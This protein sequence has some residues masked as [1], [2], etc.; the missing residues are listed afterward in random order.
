M[1]DIERIEEVLETGALGMNLYRPIEASETR[2]RFKIYHADEAVPLSNILPMMENMGFKVLGEVPFLIQVRDRSRGGAASTR[3][4]W[5]HDFEVELAG[6]G[7]IAL[8]DIRDDFQ[9]AFARVWCGA[10]ENDGFNRLVILAGL[11]WREVVV[12]RAYAKYLRQVSFTFAQTTL[13]ATLAAYPGLTRALVDLFSAWFDPAHAPKTAAKL[14]ETLLKSIALALDEV[15]SADDDRILRRFLDLVQN[16][17]RTNYFRTGEDGNPRPYLS[18]KLDSRKLDDLPLPRP[19]REIWVYSPA[20]EGIHLRG[21][22]VARGGLRWSD[23]RE[24]FRTEILGLMKAQMVKNAVIVP[25]GSKGGFVVKRPPPAEAG[26]EAWLTE[27]IACYKT[28]IRGLLDLTDNIAGPDIVPPPDVVRRDED[29][30]YLVVAADKGTASFSDIANGISL[31]YGFWLGDAF[32]S[33]GTHGYDH[34]KMG[35]TARGAWESVK[36]HFREMG[37]DTQKERHTVV[38]IGDMSG[39]V[40]GNGLLQSEHS[41]MVAA[42]NHLHIFVDPNPKTLKKAFEERRRLFDLPRSTWKDYDAELISKGGGVFDRKA[43]AVPVSPEMKERFGI[44]T[45]HI[46]P[47]E[48]IKAILRA[49]VDLIWFGGIGTYIKSSEQT[50]ADA[51]D[52]AN[53]GVRINAKELRAK[54]IGE[55]ANLA[56]TQLGRIE[57][58]LKGVRLNTDAIDNS[59]GVDCSDH[60]VNIK[61]LLNGIVADGDLTEKQRNQILEKMTDEVGHLVLR[62]NYLQTQA[63]SLVEAQAMEVLDH[64]DRFMRMLEKQDRLDRAI[65]FLPDDE[66]IAERAMTKTGLTRPEIAVLMPYAKIWL[67]DVLLASG[68]PDEP[69]L[70]EDLSRYFPA[71]VRKKYAKQIKTHRLKREIIATHVTNSMINRVGGTFV[72]QMMERTGMDPATIA[73]AYLISRDAFGLRAV[74]HAIE[75]QDAKIPSAAQIAMLIEVNRLI[76]RATL[77]LLRNGPHPLDIG[78]MTASL[79]RGVEVLNDKLR[80]LVCDEAQCIL[81]ERAKEFLDQ[82]APDELAQRIAGLIILASAFD[83]VR[84]SQSRTL[85]EETVAR[86]YFRIGERF[87]LGWLRA[88]AERE[89][90]G[91]HWQKMAVGAVIEELYTHQRELTDAVLEYGQEKADAEGGFLPDPAMIDDWSNGHR[92]VVDRADQLV[93]ELRSA[94][95]VD[96]AMLTVASRQFRALTHG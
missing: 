25:V 2:V 66:V 15:T 65:E 12:L 89:A 37:L 32:A 38:G 41:A 48:L 28:F 5:I 53:D 70:A 1:V 17:L 10:V 56:V 59:A 45:D 6:G 94:G 30:P 71:P 92:Q 49:E 24:D 58:A 84:I 79:G 3:T 80:D 60:E 9:N 86:I 16:T 87:G 73:R 40:F 64:Q 93:S 44:T 54:V 42:F 61:I 11:T 72:T 75:Q 26:R 13:E 96:L 67:Y 22:K 36:R 43:K 27:G 46:P 47:N 34:K 8:H 39:D 90:T 4:V 78:G 83:I 69:I 31:D 50:N 85:A 68:L 29:D 51:D 19:W 62:D 55:G 18:F 52:R 35:I 57:A 82:G 7:P 91:S 20:V 23:R 33:G 63:I 74:W 21:G 76:D 88:A 95:E 81:E 14:G 77:W